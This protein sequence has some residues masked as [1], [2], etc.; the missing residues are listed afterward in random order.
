MASTLTE[1]YRSA[2]I[3]HLPPSTKHNDQIATPT[4]TK[5]ATTQGS[6]TPIKAD[7]NPQTAT[8]A[9]HLSSAHQQTSS[10]SQ[11]SGLSSLAVAAMSGNR[12]KH[13][14]PQMRSV[15][16]TLSDTTQQH[17]THRETSC[18]VLHA[19]CVAS[20]IQFDPPGLMSITLSLSAPNLIHDVPPT[21]IEELLHFLG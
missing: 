6:I 9:G 13:E 19:L 7:Y 12:I 17:T 4:A 2:P 11:P 8:S 20:W 10:S 5:F 14:A 3:N 21:T 16:Y 15:G 18:G 1:T